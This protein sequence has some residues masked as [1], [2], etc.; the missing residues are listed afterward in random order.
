MR[1]VP[2]VAPHTHKH[3]RKHK[4]QY[5]VLNLL[6]IRLKVAGR[7]HLTHVET[8]R[9][10][11]SSD[12]GLT[13]IY[14]L[15]LWCLWELFPR[16]PV[17]LISYSSSRFTSI[18]LIQNVDH[19]HRGGMLGIRFNREIKQTAVIRHRVWLDKRTEVQLIYT[20]PAP[21]VVPFSVFS[22]VVPPPCTWM[23]FFSYL[24]PSA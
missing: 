4:Q 5:V 18:T 10:C 6:L 13:G 21:F 8:Q 3:S 14:P 16:S 20:R 19:P 7:S 15:D 2:A 17:L 12:P 22:H 24:C 1:T 11:T 9:G 23:S